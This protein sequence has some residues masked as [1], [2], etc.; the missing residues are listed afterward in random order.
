VGRSDT[1]RL[2]A[3]RLI[4]PLGMAAEAAQARP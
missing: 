2:L 3:R 1:A 4:G